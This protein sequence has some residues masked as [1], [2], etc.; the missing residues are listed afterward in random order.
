MENVSTADKI[1]LYVEGMGYLGM[2]L[3]KSSSFRHS[4][5]YPV[6]VKKPSR[7]IVPNDFS[8]LCVFEIELTSDYQVKGENS[9]F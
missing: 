5:F 2:C 7:R 8:N 6:L 3:P 4:K 1:T 9:N